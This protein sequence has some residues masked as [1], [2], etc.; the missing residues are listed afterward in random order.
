MSIL[1]FFTFLLILSF[2]Y[3]FSK[4]EWQLKSQNFRLAEERRIVAEMDKLKRSKKVL[5]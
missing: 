1:S 2:L 3:V 5:Q 4:M